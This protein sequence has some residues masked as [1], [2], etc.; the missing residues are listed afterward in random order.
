MARGVEKVTTTRRVEIKENTRHHN[1]L[2]LQTG[3]EEVETVG[4]SIGETLE[5]EPAKEMV[6]LVERE[7]GVIQ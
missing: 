3:L 2:L 5:V 6:R 4:N 7:F 1:D